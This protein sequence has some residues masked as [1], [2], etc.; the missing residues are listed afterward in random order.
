M[1]QMMGS[2][3][4]YWFSKK[5]GKEFSSVGGDINVSSRNQMHFRM[6]SSL[7]SNLHFFIFDFFLDRFLFVKLMSNRNIVDLVQKIHKVVDLEPILC[8]LIAMKVL[9]FSPIITKCNM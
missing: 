9:E 6:N 7:P 4:T 2:V 8:Y 1:D 3:G 5:A